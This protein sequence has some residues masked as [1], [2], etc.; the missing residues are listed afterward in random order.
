M[1]GTRFAMRA[2][3]LLDH[4]VSTLLRGARHTY[5]LGFEQL[6]LD[7][8]RRADLWEPEH[9]GPI[10][11]DLETDDGVEQV[12]GWRVLHS[13]TRGPGKGGVRFA[14]D[15]TD[16]EVRG[17]AALMSLKCALVDLPFGGAKGG[18]RVDPSRAT[19]RSAF[20]S[21][22]AEAMLPLIGPDTD[23]VG[24]DVGTGPDDMMAFVDAAA[25]ENGDRA[26]AIAT[27]KP[28]DRGGIE[29]RRGA[30]AAG[31]KIALDT[32]VEHSGESGRRVSIQGFG[33]LGRE[34]ARLLVD[35]GY[36]V[37]AVSDSSGTVADPSGID[38]DQVSSAKD[39]HG[40]FANAGLVGEHDALTVDCDIVVP[41]AL[42]GAI[43]D[44]VARALRAG[45]VV[46]GANGPTTVDAAEILAERGVIVVPDVLAN[47]GGVTASYYE[48][49]VSL[50]EIDA[51]AT[52]EPFRGR[53]LD[54]NEAVW[55]YSRTHGVDLRTAASATAL[56]RI[57]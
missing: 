9:V 50:G 36:E 34:L 2:N 25:G 43:D 22:V 11:V 14:P 6:G 26:A 4:D 33:S 24:P 44:D 39:D 18:V 20:A 45:I 10:T 17:L 53:L 37:V 13:T 49:A 46:E 56:E 28:L 40:S 51:D 21:R 5:E 29:L 7:G 38:V 3:D 48:W 19:D 42:Q 47:A 8:P 16:D 35:D 55:T 31:V 15:V 57:R 1:L 27:G 52:A 30:T 41:G 32:A 54:A 12:A 23:I